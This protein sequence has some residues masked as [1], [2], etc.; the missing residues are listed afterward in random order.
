MIR[1][2]TMHTTYQL[3]VRYGETDQMGVVYYGNYALYLEEARTDLIRK[4]GI[5]Y[6]EMEDKGVMLP[7]VESNIKYH[8]SAGYDEQI[9]MKTSIKG[10]P[11]RTIVFYTEMF[12]EKGEQLNTCSVKLL[13]VDKNTGKIVRCPDYVMEAVEQFVKKSND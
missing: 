7:V 8:K 10:R 11:S 6:K 13:F 9:T 12:N 1:F 5:S 4:S 3:R 2:T